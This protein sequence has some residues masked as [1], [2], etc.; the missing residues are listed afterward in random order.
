[1]KREASQDDAVTTGT[2]FRLSSP[3]LTS[4]PQYVMNA[5]NLRSL[6]LNNCAL[7]TIPDELFALPNMKKMSFN[8]NYVSE[9]SRE[10]I[11]RSGKKLASV[12]LENNPLAYPPPAIASKSWSSVKKW[13]AVNSSFMVY[14]LMSGSCYVDITF[15]GMTDPQS[16]VV[17]VAFFSSFFQM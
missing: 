12:L 1:M 3:T 15:S 4:V 13:A 16:K 14:R 17:S 8:G 5:S 2:K 11:L 9:I 7:T 10:A 6:E